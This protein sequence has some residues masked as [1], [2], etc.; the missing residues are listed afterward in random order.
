MV[1]PITQNPPTTTTT[2]LHSKLVRVDGDTLGG[3]VGLIDAHQTIGQLEHVITEGDDDE[4]GVLG[5]LL[6]VVVVVVV[7][8]V[9]VLMDGGGGGEGGIRG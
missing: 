9:V 1:G 5:P 8:I 2:T 7:I 6:V 3:I 4:L